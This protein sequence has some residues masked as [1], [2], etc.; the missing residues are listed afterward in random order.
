[1]QKSLFFF[2]LWKDYLIAP[3]HFPTV[4]LTT[5][6]RFISKSETAYESFSHLLLKQDGESTRKAAVKTRSD[7]QVRGFTPVV[8]II[9]FS[10][11]RKNFPGLELPQRHSEKLQVARNPADHAG[12]FFLWLLSI[13]IMT[14]IISMAAIKLNTSIE[15]FSAHL[16]LSS[17]ILISIVQ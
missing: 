11:A 9:P 3:S 14:D 1:M 10:S 17:Q 2:F 6:C 15:W 12:S 8:C 16:F 4:T 7:A 13:H 5:L